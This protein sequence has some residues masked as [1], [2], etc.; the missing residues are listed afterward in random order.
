[1][2]DTPALA[3]PVP[4]IGRAAALALLSYP[5]FSTADALVKLAAARLPVEQIALLMSGF[6]LLPVLFLAR[7]VGGLAAFRPRR[8][9]LVLARG[10]STALCALAA[11][12]PSRSCPWPMLMRS[13]SS[14]RSW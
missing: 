3:A 6:A 8:P 12:G 4:A 7:G 1:M 5:C 14:P 13:S 11:C 10:V 2:T 9:G